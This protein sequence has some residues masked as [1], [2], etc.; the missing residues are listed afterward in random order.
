MRAFL[1]PL[2]IN[3]GAVGA[4]ITWA[5]GLKDLGKQLTNVSIVQ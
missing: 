4:G 2:A 1:R 5:R 3:S